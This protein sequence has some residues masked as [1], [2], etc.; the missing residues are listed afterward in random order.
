LGVS[1]LGV[2][3][4]VADQNDFID[5]EHLLIIADLCKKCVRILRDSFRAGWL[6]SHTRG[7]GSAG[8]SR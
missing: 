2:A 1:E 3:G 6:G 5:A 7:A 4:G 8:G